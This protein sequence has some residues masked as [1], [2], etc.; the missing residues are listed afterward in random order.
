MSPPP[1]TLPITNNIYIQKNILLA[2]YVP[3][4][5]HAQA[6]QHAISA[7]VLLVNNGFQEESDVADKII[8][9]TWTPV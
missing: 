3:I 6:W 7:G 9:F 5:S 1:P 8:P 2:T 4:A